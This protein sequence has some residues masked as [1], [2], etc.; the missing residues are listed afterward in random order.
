MAMKPKIFFYLV[1][2]F[3]GGLWIAFISSARFSNWLLERQQNPDRPAVIYTAAE[4]TWAKKLKTLLRPVIALG[5]WAMYL[6]V[7]VIGVAVVFAAAQ[8]LLVQFDKPK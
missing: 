6:P 5:D 3:G 1:L 4:G 7:I 2:V 8:A